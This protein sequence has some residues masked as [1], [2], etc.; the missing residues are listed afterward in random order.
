LEFAHQPV[1]VHEVLEGLQPVS[2]GIY[3]DGTVGSGGHS[4]EIGKALG[5][6][7]RLICLDRDPDAIRLSRKR[8]AFLKNAV[9]FFQV[10]YSDLDLIIETLGETTINGVL[11]DL[12]MSSNQLEKSGRGFSFLRDEHLDMRMNPE[13]EITA[14]QLVNNLQPKDLEKILKEYGEEKKARLI[15]RV[16]IKAREKRPIET[17][18]QLAGIIKSAIPESPRPGAKHPATKT[19][20]AL[21]IAVNG[22]LQHI[23]NFLNKIPSLISKKGR[24]VVLSYHSL[25]DR[26]I[27]HAMMNWEKACTCPVDFP[28]CI[29]GRVPLFRRVSRKGITPGQA[30]INRNPRARSAVMR[31]AERI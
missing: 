2:D 13:D 28:Q 29:C 20:Q 26:L 8:L 10:N 7:G 30:E 21:R 15:T 31:V 25:E 4:L 23:E 19:F 3:V 9:S 14:Y 16:I 24:L 6:N 1:L 17:S 12:G 27:K 22:E 5:P 18:F 11:L